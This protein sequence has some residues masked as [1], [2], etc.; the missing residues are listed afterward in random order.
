MAFASRADAVI[1]GE[2]GGPLESSAVMVLTAGG[3]I[4]TGIVVAHDAVLTAAHCAR[5]TASVRVHFREAGQAVL[6]EPAAVERHPGF[7]PNAVAERVRSIDLALLR[8]DA[9]LPARFRPAQLSTANP[10]AG[11][12]IVTG[13]FGLT[14]EGDA[15]STGTWRSA[16]LEAVEP[17]G[18]SNVLIWARGAGGRGA[19][20]GDSGGPLSQA[21]RVV[22]VV[23]WSTGAGGRQCGELTQGALVG[24]QRPWIDA[25]LARWSSE[26]SWR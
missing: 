7:R 19:C 9:E 23:T 18:R 22:A 13:G 25:I 14:R 6:L 15:S 10:A 12:E 3:G 1:G 16:R 17:H 4:C 24:P 2:P 8:L 21:G 11:A 20:Q 26:A 5:S